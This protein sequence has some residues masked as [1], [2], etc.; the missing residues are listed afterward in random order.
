MP[1]LVQGTGRR[2]NLNVEKLELKSVFKFTKY[3][4]ARTLWT[5]GAAQP[6][7]AQS[8]H[9]CRRVSGRHT[10]SDNCYCSFLPRPSTWAPPSCTLQIHLH[11]WWQR[12]CPAQGCAGP[13][14]GWVTWNYTH[15]CTTTAPTAREAQHSHLIPSISSFFVQDTSLFPFQAYINFAFLHFNIN[16]C[17]MD[18][19]SCCFKPGQAT[20]LD[21]FKNSKYLH[22]PK[23]HLT[24][25]FPR[26]FSVCEFR[27]KQ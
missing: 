14:C 1:L 15:L 27:T 25:I 24:T 6:G 5:S 23:P 3:N 12:L 17:V 2:R 13:A 21:E 8:E 9:Y 16:T 18:S 19:H 4:E 10:S 26:D 7:I 11:T 22:S 20:S